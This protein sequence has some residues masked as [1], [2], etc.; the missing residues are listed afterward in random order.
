VEQEI[1]KAQI[2]LGKKIYQREPT[3]RD[4]AKSN[5]PRTQ[6]GQGDVDDGRRA[7]PTGIGQG[8]QQFVRTSGVRQSAN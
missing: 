5:G 2:A 7:G 6:Q 8:L 1:G 3:G 4:F